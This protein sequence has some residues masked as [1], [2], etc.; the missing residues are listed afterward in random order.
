MS[1]IKLFCVATHSH[2]HKLFFSN[3][4]VNVTEVEIA[5]HYYD[6]FGIWV[7]SSK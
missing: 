1:M 5:T 2:I 4:P 6:R 3:L 7:K